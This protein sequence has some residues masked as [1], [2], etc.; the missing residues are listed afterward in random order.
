MNT[1]K[2]NKLK[3]Y[4][5][6][7]VKTPDGQFTRGFSLPLQE[8]RHPTHAGYLANILSNWPHV[9]DL[10]IGVLSDLL[11]STPHAPARQ[12]FKSIISNQARQ[13]VMLALLQRAKI[14]RDKGKQYDEIITQFHELN[15]CRNIYVHGLWFTHVNTGKVFLAEESLDDHHFFESREVPIQEMEGMVNRMWA[16]TNKIRNR[17]KPNWVTVSA[18]PETPPQP[19]RVNKKEARQARQTKRA[20]P[21]PPPEPSQG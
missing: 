3:R 7:D 17:A 13:K 21:H 2:Q 15:A 16:L 12:I 9:E 4:T 6:P 20:K 11:G 5:D 18:S 10:M 14:N 19:H 1:P 8:L